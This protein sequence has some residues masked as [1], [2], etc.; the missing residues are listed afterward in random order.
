MA[1][2]QGG[3]YTRT[4]RVFLNVSKG[5]LSNNKEGKHIDGYIGRL[6]E[7]KFVTE[8]F[9]GQPTPKWKVVMKNMADPEGSEAQIAFKADAYYALGWFRRILNV[10]LARPFLMGVYRPKDSNEKISMCYLMQ[11]EQKI[12]ADKE[13]IPD[14]VKVMVGTKEIMDWTKTLEVCNQIA[15][16]VQEKIRVASR[17]LAQQAPAAPEYEG[18]PLGEE[19]PR[20]EDLPF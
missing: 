20:R 16:E 9:E 13:R 19:P 10:N 3:E 18:P 7:L 8:T 12:E 1:Q 6:T 14:P 17:L 11:D 5:K 4:P 15:L 2:N